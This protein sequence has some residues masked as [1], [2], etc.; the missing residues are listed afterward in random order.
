MGITR[1]GT[2]VITRSRAL[3]YQMG[4]WPGSP[5]LPA[6]DLST[7]PLNG[8]QHVVGDPGLW[9][10]NQELA[11][12]AATCQLVT[13]YLNPADASWK[14]AVANFEDVNPQNVITGLLQMGWCFRP[15]TPINQ[16]PTYEQAI[17]SRS[18]HALDVQELN[19]MGPGPEVRKR[20]GF[21]AA[22]PFMGITLGDMVR[23]IAQSERVDPSLALALVQRESAFD[24]TAQSP[25][26][27]KG[28]TQLKDG[29]AADMGVKNVWDPADNVRG[30]LR[31]LKRMLDRSASVFEALA[32]YHSGSHAIDERG[33]SNADGRYANDI[34]E[35]QRYYQQKG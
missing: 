23:A 2:L 3:A 8:T 1:K 21:S 33:Y 12:Y 26:G 24:P 15:T 35:L 6:W 4:R 9:S 5:F 18:R 7:V 11:T 27:A 10:T 20:T 34:L 31:Y 28:L 19:T 30:G 25:A 32:R 22:T 13:W 14:L 17:I 29:A 16:R